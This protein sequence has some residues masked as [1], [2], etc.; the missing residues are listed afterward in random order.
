MMGLEEFC[1]MLNAKGGASF[2]LKNVR[3]TKADKYRRRLDDILSGR[4]PEPGVRGKLIVTEPD[5]TRIEYEIE[6]TGL[7]IGEPIRGD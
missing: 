4:D 2:I 7:D 6:S 1:R 5:G 3:V